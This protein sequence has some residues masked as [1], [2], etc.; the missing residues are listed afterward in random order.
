MKKIFFLSLLF[1]CH[2]EELKKD[3]ITILITSYK[4]P[5]CYGTAHSRSLCKSIMIN[6]IGRCNG[7]MMQKWTWEGGGLKLTKYWDPLCSYVDN[8]I[9][10]LPGCSPSYDGSES[11][12]FLNNYSCFYSQPPDSITSQETN[13]IFWASIII[14]LVSTLCIVMKTFVSKLRKL[15]ETE[16]L[17]N[18][19]HILFSNEET[20]L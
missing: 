11:T 20:S 8:F 2:C 3:F 19:T 4:T 7:L 18:K 5:N 1:L 14:F 17:L 15:P 16:T 12:Q 6:D 9:M 10:Y 13:N